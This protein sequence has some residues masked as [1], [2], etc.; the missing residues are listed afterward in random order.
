MLS[1]DFKAAN[2]EF[3]D[4]GDL[5]GIR[6]TTVEYVELVLDGR[7]LPVLE[8]GYLEGYRRLTGKKEKGGGCWRNFCK[9][10][11]TVSVERS[12]GLGYGE[13]QRALD[14]DH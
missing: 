7:G 9:G 1:L 3:V 5:G 10:N 2:V 12:M 6:D 14:R 4:C 13:N 11:D 8:I